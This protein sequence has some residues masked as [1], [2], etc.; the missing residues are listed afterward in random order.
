MASSSVSVNTNPVANQYTGWNERIIEFDS[1]NGG[2]LIGFKV[3]E[4][5]TLRVDVYRTDE[6][7]VVS[8]DRP[9]YEEVNGRR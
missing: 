6:T 2:G 9:T 8:T 5:G 7:V 3:L 4:D 1:P